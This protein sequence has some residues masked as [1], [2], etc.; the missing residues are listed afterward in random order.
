MDEVVLAADAAELL[1]RD[2]RRSISTFVRAIRQQTGTVKSAQSETLDLLH[3]LGAM[4]VA[5]LAERR[6]V[7]HQTMRL[8]VAQL[9]ADK[10]VRQDADP[11][12]RRSRLISI[13]PGGIDMIVRQKEARESR[14]EDAICRLLSRRERE[15][16]RSAIPILDRLAESAY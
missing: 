6:C 11:A 15:L 10:L 13:T 16:L 1:A 14:I 5:R 2:L 7:T 9:D 8:V 3:R 12:D 4:N